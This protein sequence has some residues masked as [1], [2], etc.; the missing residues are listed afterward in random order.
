MMLDRLG[1]NDHAVHAMRFTP[2]V[3]ASFRRMVG[4]QRQQD[5]GARDPGSS[6]LRPPLFH[7]DGG[8]CQTVATVSALSQPAFRPEAGSA[9]NA[10]YR[11][12]CFC[13]EQSAHKRINASSADFVLLA[14]QAIG[15]GPPSCH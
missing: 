10:L 8:S 3:Y 1:T 7:R 12:I 5:D 15:P 2:A 13:R 11:A 4:V 14:A 6:L 9:Y